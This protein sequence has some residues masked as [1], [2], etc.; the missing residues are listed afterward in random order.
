MND[1]SQYS[2]VRPYRLAANVALD[3]PLWENLGLVAVLDAAETCFQTRNCGAQLPPWNPPHGDGDAR[4]REM[5]GLAGSIGE[6]LT[7]AAACE[8]EIELLRRED[9]HRTEIGQRFFS[10][11]ESQE[12]VGVGHRLLNMVVR[13]MTCHPGLQ[14]HVRSNERLK[15]PANHEPFS[16]DRSA[17]LALNKAATGELDAV[18]R[19]TS[20]RSIRRLAAELAVLVRSS[21]WEQLE[22]TRGVVFHR[23]R[24]ESSIVTGI[25]GKAGY[26]RELLGHDGQV[27]GYSY[28]ESLSRYSAGDGRLAHEMTV[29]RRALD[30]LAATSAA[31]SVTVLAALEPLTAGRHWCEMRGSGPVK[32]TH[33][34]IGG[35]WLEGNCRCCAEAT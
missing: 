14:A 31:V 29:A 32:M 23:S 19:F 34:L 7:V 3:E 13:A 18:V 17:W 1:Q 22:E 5:F 16:H 24:P 6:S 11:A 20:H 9:D 8:V 25:D 15:G 30:R 12:L 35:A 28:G 4:L 33:Q 10:I 21:E 27:V 2:W 26:G